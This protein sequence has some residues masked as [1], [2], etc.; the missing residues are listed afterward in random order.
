MKEGTRHISVLAPS[1]LLLRHSTHFGSGTFGTTMPSRNSYSSAQAALSYL[2][3][4]TLPKLST[5]AKELL[6]HLK[7]RL[8]KLPIVRPRQHF[9]IS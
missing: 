8:P 1:V 3:K 6:S 7:E 4:S 2:L 9:P 5:L